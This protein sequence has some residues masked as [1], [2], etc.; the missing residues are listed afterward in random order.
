MYNIHVYITCTIYMWNLTVLSMFLGC[1]DV[2]SAKDVLLV[3]SQTNILAY[4]IDNNKELFHNE[5]RWTLFLFRSLCCNF[6]N[7]LLMMFQVSDGANTLLVGCHLHNNEPL[8]YV[9]GNCSITG[10]DKD[11]CDRFWTVSQ[12][13]LLMNDYASC[14]VLTCTCTRFV[15]LRCII[16]SFSLFLPP[17]SLALFLF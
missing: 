9:G 11:G 6:I 5:V 15:H 7:S 3:G 12:T 1:L 2:T 10:F 17:L 8:V 4:D 13:G 16:L 14:T